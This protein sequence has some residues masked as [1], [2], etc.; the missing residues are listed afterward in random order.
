MKKETLSQVFS[1]KLKDS[2]IL[3]K[4]SLMIEL[5]SFHSDGIR[6]FRKIP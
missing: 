6:K 2:L 4:S 5:K 3:L 1:C